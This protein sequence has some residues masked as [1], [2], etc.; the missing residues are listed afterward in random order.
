MPDP[1]RK[2]ISATEAPGLFNVSPYVTRWMLWNKFAKGVDIDSSE[3]ARMSWG[4]K[5]QPLV[6]EQ[7]SEELALE[8]HP[9][10]DDVYIRRG[11]LGCT[12]DAQIICPDRGPGALETKCVFDYG[13][14]MRDWKGGKFVPRYHEIQLQQQMFVGDENGS[15]G[16]GVIAAWVAGEQ[17][18]FERQPIPALWE[19]LKDEAA[20]FM[21]SVERKQEPEPFG[22]AIEIP[23]LTELLPTIEGN[24]L[25]LSAEPSAEALANDASMFNYHQEQESGH[26]K[27]REAL[28][29]KFLAVGKDHDEIRLPFGANIRISTTKGASP[30]K[31]LKV[32]VPETLGAGA[33]VNNDILAAG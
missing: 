13:T 19:K 32:Y 2:T 5:L 1:L 31:R 26:K 14:W 25:D 21:M 3:D 6:L 33:P 28:R 7:A 12:R 24:P 8:V 10:A 9:N 20:S 18:Y 11:L 17:H 15:F 29:A 4:K 23:W 22:V 27:A 30:Q 16:W